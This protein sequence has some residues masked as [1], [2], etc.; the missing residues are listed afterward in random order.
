MAKLIIIIFFIST[1][2]GSYYLTYQGIGQEE[3]VTVDKHSIRT[4]SSSSSRHYRSNGG[5]YSGG[6]SYGK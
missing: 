4:Q 5:S 1:V 3:I 6:Y 2:F